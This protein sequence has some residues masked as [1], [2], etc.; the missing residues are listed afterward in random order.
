MQ[1]ERSGDAQQR[2]ERILRTCQ[3]LREAIGQRQPVMAFHNDCLITFCPHLL[4]QRPDGPYVLAFVVTA[5]LALAAERL[6]SPRRWRW[7]AAADLR[8]AT[9]GLGPWL[10]SPRHTRPRLEDFPAEVEAA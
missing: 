3:L 1:R 7:L 4:G 9:P 10:S 8:G 2:E 5:E 6:R